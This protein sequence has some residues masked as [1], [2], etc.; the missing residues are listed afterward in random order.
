MTDELKLYFMEN[1]IDNIRL[2][3]A[4]VMY[5]SCLYDTPAA[6][7]VCITAIDICIYSHGLHEVFIEV[8]II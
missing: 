7:Y 3:T 6:H 1:I 5:L 8:K 4:T 2:A